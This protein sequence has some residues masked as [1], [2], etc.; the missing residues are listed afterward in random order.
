VNSVVVGFLGA[1]VTAAILGLA[2]MAVGIQQSIRQN[3]KAINRAAKMLSETR[4]NED[5][6]RAAFELK[7]IGDLVEPMV[8]KMERLAASVDAFYSVAVANLGVAGSSPSPGS[9]PDEDGTTFGGV[10][11]ERPRPEPGTER[12]WAA[13]LDDTETIADLT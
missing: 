10:E 9:F 5:L 3:T 2:Y 8:R 4:T 12:G 13:E 6:K 1:I 11:A 7:R